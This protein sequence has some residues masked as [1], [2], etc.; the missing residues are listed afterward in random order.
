[1]RFKDY[2][3]SDYEV[4]NRTDR[5][6]CLKKFLGREHEAVI[7]K[8]L[9]LLRRE[10]Y[11]AFKNILPLSFIYRYRKNKLGE[12]LGFTIHKHVFGPGLRIWHYGNI[13]VSSQAR[14]GKNCILH[15]DNCI[16]NKGFGSHGKSPI[17]GDNVDI[18]VGAKILGD[19][20]IANNVTIAAGAV[21]VHS[22]EEQ[23]VILAGIPA[24][25]ICHKNNGVEKKENMNG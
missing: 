7:W 2:L 6:H 19:I 17:I 1:M 13:V 20:T 25:V 21:V 11:Y 5:V 16:G 4:N 9:K 22:C 23:H 12:R 18:G 10:E 15:G 24:K 8:Y 3:A 14:V